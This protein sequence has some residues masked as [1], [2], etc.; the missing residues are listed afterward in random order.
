MNRGFG[1]DNHSGI[2]PEI[3]EAIG[4]A[5]TVHALAYGEDEYTVALEKEIKR[6]FG[7]QATIYPVFNGTGANVLCID[8][9][10]RSHNAVICAE[11]AHINVDE[12]GA[13]QRITGAKLLTVATPDGKLT[14]E[15]IKQHLHGIGFQHHS[16]PRVVSVAQST[17]LGT[18]YTLK[19]L[20]TLSDFVHANN[21]LLHIDGA[22][23][24]NA[25]VALGCTF[26]QM[27]T[28]I[29]AD[30]VSFGGTKNG[31]MMGESVVLLN[32]ALN[33]DFLY[34]RKQAMQLCS[35]MRFVS[36]QF[37]AYLE[38]DLW[39]RNAEHSN[40]MAQLLYQQVKDLPGLEIMYPVQVNA[41]FAKLPHEVWTKLLE[42]YFF[43][44]WD[45]AENVVRW[46]C[47]F[48]TQKEDILQ[49]VECLKGILN[50]YNN[51]K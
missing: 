11:T 19:E 30:A 32:P 43:Y 3:L 16:Q 1:S 5:N 31:L 39:R 45:E 34:R 49:F 10:L 15:M 21:M 51:K 13:P 22:R 2:S 36:A 24:A 7:Q 8:A 42:H 20:K 28:D 46:M 40:A 48:D 9:M 38:N 27:T 26:R 12:C 44:D 29:G 41:V 50:D 6:H 4:K 18:L 25:A 17:E 33:E 23:L 37:L 14:P 47:S 35:K